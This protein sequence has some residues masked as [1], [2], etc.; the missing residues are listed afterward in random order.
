MTPAAAS[1]SA[2]REGQRKILSGIVV[3]DK[4]DKTRI[5]LVERTVRHP[6]Y[7]K[8]IGKRKKFSVHDEKNESVAGDWV[9]IMSARPMSKTKRWRL[10]R[11][12]RQAPDRSA[13]QRQQAAKE[14][15]AL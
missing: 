5:V 10:L 9:E 1:T 7:E 15:A 6:L 3:S 8:T 14:K 4:M 11:I 2:E 13:S 12:V